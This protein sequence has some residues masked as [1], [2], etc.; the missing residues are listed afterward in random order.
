MLDLND[1]KLCGILT[2]NKIVGD[3][4]T[5]V[6]GIGINA[7]KQ[8]FPSFELNKPIS[9]EEVLNYA[10]NSNEIISEILNSFI[11][12]DTLFNS[13]KFISE[14]KERSLILNKEVLYINGNDKINAE[15]IDINSDCSLKLKAGSGEIINATSGEIRLQ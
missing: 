2:E 10:P 8:E 3:S 9:L 4:V 6:I 7:L 12:F 5:S 11:N 14:Y 15:V 1:K 13:N